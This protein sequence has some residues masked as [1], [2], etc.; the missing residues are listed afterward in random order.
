MP[1]L[2][3][4]DADA[5]AASEYV[6]KQLPDPKLVTVFAGA[7]ANKEIIEVGEILKAGGMCAVWHNCKVSNEEVAFV[8]GNVAGSVVFIADCTTVNATL[9]G[10]I[11]VLACFGLC[12][13]VACLLFVNVYRTHPV[14]RV[15]QPFFLVLIC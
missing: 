10:F 2:V 6:I 12:M 13:A 4:D 7:C 14:V 15:A 1:R 8:H 5:A 3:Y 11:V 9:K